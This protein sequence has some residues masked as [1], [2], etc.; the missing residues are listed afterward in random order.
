MPICNRGPPHRPEY[1]VKL[2]QQDAPGIS[3]LAVKL[4]ITTY[5]P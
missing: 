2:Q 3:G 5:S 4:R 1:Y